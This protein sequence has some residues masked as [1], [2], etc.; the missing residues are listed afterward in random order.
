MTNRASVTKA[1][2]GG[3]SR[4]LATRVDVL[5]VEVENLRR[6]MSAQERREKARD[7]EVAEKFALLTER[8]SGVDTRL[9]L[10]VEKV[11]AVQSRVSDTWDC[12]DKIRE[13]QE[14]SFKALNDRL[15]TGLVALHT[16]LNSLGCAPEPRAKEETH[17]V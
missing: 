6:R 16:R 9:G 10:L 5:G 13:G 4:T 7:A 17:E 11:G 2:R 12:M 15:D 8:V 14:K 1:K 3:G